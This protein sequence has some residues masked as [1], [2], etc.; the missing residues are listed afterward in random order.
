VPPQIRELLSSVGHLTVDSVSQAPFCLEWGDPRGPRFFRDHASAEGYTALPVREGRSINCI[1][2]TAE[3]ADVTDWARVPLGR[4]IEVDDLVARDAPLFSLLP[5]L[6]HRELLLCLGREGIDGVVT[7]YDLNQPA[8][9]MFA[10]G[11][12]LLIE[13]E[14]A[15]AITNSLRDQRAVEEHVIAVLG[16]KN[17]QIRRWQ[18]AA[19]TSEQVEILNYL[20]FYEKMRCLTDGAAD[21]LSALAAVHPVELRGQLREVQQLRNSIAHYAAFELANYRTV[22]QRMRTAYRLARRFNESSLEQPSMP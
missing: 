6:D 20:T 8:A 9:H 4:P 18:K 14:I 7:V 2:Q 17:R 22:V 11:L 3:L 12:A 16:V 1:V 5:R 19:E 13:V 10:L 15:A 21:V